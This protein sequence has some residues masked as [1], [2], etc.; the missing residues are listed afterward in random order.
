MPENGPDRGWTLRGV[1]ACADLWFPLAEGGNTIGARRANHVCLD[2]AGVSK[3]HALVRTR[4]DRVTIED[5]ASRNG[6]VVNGARTRH[7]E[8]EAG[9]TIRLGSAVLTL[10]T[11]SAEDTRLAIE[12]GLRAHTEG[13]SAMRETPW[14]APDETPAAPPPSR[15]VHLPDGWLPGTSPAMRDLL[16]QIRA[17]AHAELPVLVRGETGVGKE[18]IAEAL[19]RSSRRA[20]GPF[21]AINC[22]AIPDALLEAE[23]F[24]VGAGVATGVTARPGRF[25]EADTGTLLLDEIGDMPGTLQAKLL[26]VLQEGVVEPLGRRR[27]ALDV[28]VIAATHTDLEASMA[29]GGFR[30]DLYYRLAGVTLQVPPLRARRED[31]PELVRHF[32]RRAV[33]RHGNDVRGVTRGALARLVDHPWPGNVRELQ[34][35]VARCV[36][37]CAPHQA[38]HE[39]HLDAHLAPPPS[40]APVTATDATTSSATESRPAGRHR[41]GG[42]DPASLPSL[43]LTAIEKAVIAEALRRA[44]GQLTRAAASLGLSRQALRRRIAR[45]GLDKHDAP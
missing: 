34:H 30:R 21:V 37:H 19:H 4:G 25:A 27:Q 7:A 8:L 38:I 22:A 26:R 1:G 29:A 18:G 20:H 2:R 39:Q 33:D 24:G 36:L 43:D 40:P 17:I 14:L 44:R 23:L 9:D 41:V 13:D 45:H 32:L 12:L 16:A 5:L 6:T 3:R 10:D 11:A 42:L 31:I 15:I 28:R 35:T